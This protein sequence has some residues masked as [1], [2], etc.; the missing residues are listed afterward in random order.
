MDFFVLLLKGVFAMPIYKMSGL[1][2]CQIPFNHA[3]FFSIID[4]CLVYYKGISVDGK[5]MKSLYLYKNRN[6]IMF[7]NL[8]KSFGKF[9][10]KL[11]FDLITFEWIIIIHSEQIKSDALVFS[12][13]IQLIDQL[14]KVDL[15][16]LLMFLAV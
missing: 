1:S 15:I 10:I 7:V 11:E 14:T 8:T 4:A 13:N 12:L 3:F 5:F 9:Q 6:P 2:K 16:L